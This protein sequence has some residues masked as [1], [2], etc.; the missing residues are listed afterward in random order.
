MSNSNIKPGA[1]YLFYGFYTTDAGSFL[2]E[3]GD[4]T[5]NF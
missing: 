5:L 2:S 4:I 1:A 3:L